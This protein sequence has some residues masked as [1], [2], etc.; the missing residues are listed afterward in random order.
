M[1]IRH[2]GAA[3]A[4]LLVFLLGCGGPIAPAEPL[5]PRGLVSSNLVA[6]NG[7]A[8]NGIA[9]NGIAI[10]GI[11]INGLEGGPTNGLAPGAGS[12]GLA[13]NG[14]TQE[15]LATP[16]FQAWFAIDPAYSSSV[17]TYLVRCALGPEKTLVYSHG[18]ASYAWTGTLAVAPVWATGIAIEP[19]EQQL[20][21]AC[22]AAH[23]NGLGQHVDISVRG[24][25]ADGTTIP[26]TDAEAAGWTNREACFFGNLFDG[27]GVWD[28]LEPDLLDPV[29]S[30][31]RGCAA[32]FGVAQSCP[33]MMQA[34]MC[35]DICA[36]GPDGVTW[37]DCAVN[38]IH[39]RPLR[40]FLQASDVYRCGDG[41]CQSVTENGTT[42]AADC[43][44]PPATP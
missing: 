29:I 25:L 44:P 39:Y 19:A 10:N 12:N 1:S 43:S 36:V 21:S 42:C 7:I 41:V 9:I 30:T 28:A 27:T 26:V 13:V 24:Y 4:A 15:A 40:V 2:V 32:E 18:E 14:L 16:E 33:P 35:A 20:V 38:G 8:I 11:A 5:S 17:M 31:P 22:L 3:S 34:G 37:N 23:V 6:Q